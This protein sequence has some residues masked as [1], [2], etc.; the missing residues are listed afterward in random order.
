[1]PDPVGPLL[2]AAVV[3]R[4]LIL[5]EY[6]LVAGVLPE[7]LLLLP[8]LLLPLLVEP[9]LSSVLVEKD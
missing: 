4:F 2:F 3:C 9:A 1:M 6:H 5:A 7:A 8:F